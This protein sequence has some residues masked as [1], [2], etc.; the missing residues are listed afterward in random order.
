MKTQLFN[1]H[2]EALAVLGEIDRVGRCAEDRHARALERQRELERRLAAELHDHPV[3]LLALDDRQHVFERQR[4]EVQ[5]VGGVVVGRD[6]L[7]VAVDHDGLEAVLSQREG[8]VH[9]AVVELDALA[10]AV[11]PAAEDH[12]FLRAIVGVASSSPS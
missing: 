2:V 10:D 5:P 11:G 12:D 7:R 6:G 9:A 8:R 4:L 1:Q 3:G